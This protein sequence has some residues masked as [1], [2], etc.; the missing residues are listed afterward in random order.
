MKDNLVEKIIIEKEENDTPKVEEKDKTIKKNTFWSLTYKERLGAFIFFN[1]LGYI[2]QLGSISKLYSSIMKNDPGQFA[3][4]Y[5]IGNVLSLTGTFIFF[6]LRKQLSTMTHKDRRIV[7]YVFFGSLL[8]SIV[9]PL[10]YDSGV[11]RL[12]TLLAVLT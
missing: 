2:L 10:V 1:I 4:I 7:S 6:G 11:G 5:S 12:L 9:I 3:F 8:F